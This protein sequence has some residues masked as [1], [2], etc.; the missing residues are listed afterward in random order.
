MIAFAIMGLLTASIFSFH[1]ARDCSHILARYKTG[2]YTKG[3]VTKS[4][5]VH[6][7]DGYQMRYRLS[8]TTSNG[9]SHK[10]AF[11]S[12]ILYD[13]GE[14]VGVYYMPELP[15]DILIDNVENG[16][17]RIVLLYAVS[18]CFF[19]LFLWINLLAYI[20]A[21]SSYLIAAG[22]NGAFMSP[23]VGSSCSSIL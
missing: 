22:D 2:V 12:A 10:G 4:G 16:N 11:N 19:S 5:K 7:C 23:W 15:G 13:I 8:Y 9:I 20:K 1:G 18:I 21:R 17:L 3:M 14:G 6:T